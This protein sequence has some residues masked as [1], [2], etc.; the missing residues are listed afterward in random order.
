[1]RGGALRA[2]SREPTAALQLRTVL[3]DGRYPSI[4]FLELCV[5][6]VGPRRPVGR[7]SVSACG[8]DRLELIAQG[9]AVWSSATLKAGND[10][11]INRVDDVS[12][13]TYR[14]WP[15]G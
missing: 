13:P 7:C 5:I 6:R 3:V 10:R 2:F 9:L 8:W 15:D 1:M 11:R 4:R 14:H 12:L